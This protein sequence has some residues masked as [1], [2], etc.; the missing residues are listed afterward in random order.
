MEKFNKEVR[1][2]KS[3]YKISSPLQIRETTNYTNE[4][5]IFWVGG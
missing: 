2:Q 4:T 3:E 5:N 1:S